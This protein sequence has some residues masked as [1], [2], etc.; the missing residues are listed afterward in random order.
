MNQVLNSAVVVAGLVITLSGAVSWGQVPPTNDT[1]DGSS[2]GNTGGGTDA[3]AGATGTGNTAYG[4][5]AL[6]TKTSGS[7]NTTHGWQTL[8]S[9]TTS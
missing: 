6:Q 2:T 1:S 8:F 3:L 4:W 9:N 5:K 7:Y